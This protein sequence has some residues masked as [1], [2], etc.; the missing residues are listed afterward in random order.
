MSGT[1]TV[2]PTSAP[3]ATQQTSQK[4]PNDNWPNQG[5]NPGTPRDQ[6]R[7]P[8]EGPGGR[9]GGGGD[10]GDGHGD[11]GIWTTHKTR[12]WIE[13][14][15]SPI[16]NEIKLKPMFSGK[17][18]YKGLGYDVTSWLDIFEDAIEA[19]EA[20]SGIKWTDEQ[21]SHGLL[22]NFTGS[23]KSFAQDSKKQAPT[24]SHQIMAGT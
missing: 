4:T 10:S 3:A 7:Q 5:S 1:H 2:T 8:N 14:T 15:P 9:S 17:Q 18:E 13:L 22:Q 20:F 12:A 6:Q 21:M 19:E 23:A 11:Y 16:A 24:R